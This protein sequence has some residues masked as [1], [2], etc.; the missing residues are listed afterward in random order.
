MSDR[1][2]Y[3]LIG[4]VIGG[5]Y[6]VTKLLGEGGMGNVYL[7]EHT[8][9]QKK[10]AIK[11]L[12][13]EQSEKKDIMERFKR[14]AIAAS[15]I[16]QE[17][18]VDVTDFGYTPDG[19]AF[20]VMEYIE[21]ESLAEYMR[22]K[23]PVLPLHITV[24][25]ASQI[26]FALF[27]AHKKGIIHRDLKPENILLTE[28]EN[29]NPFVKI[30]D[31]GI[32]KIQDSENKT[33][34]QLTKAGAIFGTPEYMSPE[35]AGGKKVSPSSDIYSLGV[36]M[37]E[38][39]AGKLPFSDDNYMK[40]LHKHQ[41]EIPDMPSA[42]NSSVPSSMDRIIMSCLE[43]HPEKRFSSMFR[44][45]GALQR[46]YTQH[47]LYEKLNLSFLFES[48]LLS[49]LPDRTVSG[50]SATDATRYLNER[51]THDTEE[52]MSFDDMKK[53]AGRK[54]GI[55][56]VITG[57]IV[58]ASVVTGILFIK[59]SKEP[60]VA[61]RKNAQAKELSDVDMITEK[62]QD[63]KKDLKTEKE[64]NKKKIK[65]RRSSRK[66]VSARKVQKK[67]EKITMK[68]HSNVSGVEVYDKEKNKYLCKTPCSIKL[69]LDRTAVMIL[70]FKKEN[71]KIKPV[72]VR[73][74]KNITVNVDLKTEIE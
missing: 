42:V 56:T 70:G 20:F 12:H 47:K 44:L 46:V 9:L 2:R 51:E 55:L 7:A 37:Y 27:R 40:V 43:K 71:Y 4:T 62:I 33:G 5:R 1:N 65:K 30:V 59:R 22:N 36:L 24:S 17:N 15:N 49:S 3:S 8:I 32:S 16:G 14:E 52:D 39:I 31:F 53:L 48:T 50:M 66:A 60:L 29:T 34:K 21:G 64:S 58:I 67:T 41:Y 73:L 11:V 25:V 13:M 6:K 54:T 69:P 68:V 38:M 45:L 63:E 26:A 61:V 10:I 18:I 19:N 35:Q 57:M 28:K 23:G 74:D 72:V